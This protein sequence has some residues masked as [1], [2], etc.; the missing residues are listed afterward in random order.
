MSLHADESGEER[1]LL[2]VRRAAWARE[3]AGLPPVVEPE[4]R[5]LERRDR[6]SPGA[7]GAFTGAVGLLAGIAAAQALDPTIV[8]RALDASAKLTGLARDPSIAASIAATLLTG[9]IVGAT[10]AGLTRNLRKVFPL[11][12]WS[13]VFFASVAL[14]AHAAVV[15]FTALGA[16]TT[17]RA[18]FAGVGV[19]AI[20]AA[21]S[22]PLRRRRPAPWLEV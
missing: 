17:P 21:L 1:P 5:R 20:A 9:A 12:L 11:V 16:P 4:A 8:P 15:S 2:L 3:D 18:L 6:L 19:F 10:F 13:L 22:L 7:A 14:V